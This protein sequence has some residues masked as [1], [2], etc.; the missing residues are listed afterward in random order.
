MGKK[1]YIIPIFV[2]H[3]GCPFDCVFCNQRKITGK[4]TALTGQEIE[5][6]IKEYVESIGEKKDKHIEIAFFGG[7][8]TGIDSEKQKEFLSIANKWYKS[9]YVDD[10]RLSTRPD[11]ID[12]DILLNLKE[13]NVS[14]IELGVQSLDDEVLRESCRGHI[15]HDV[16]SASY[17]IKKMGFKLGLQMMIGLPGDNFEKAMNT[18]KKMISYKPDF[19]RIYP[20]LVIKGTKLEELFFKNEYKPL[21]IDNAV[22]ICRELY[23]LFYR[24]DIPI[25]RIGLQPTENIMEGKDVVAGPFHPAFRQLVESEV[26]REAIDKVIASYKHEV[27]KV[28]FTLNPKFIS[29]LVGINKSNTIYFKSK[30]NIKNI[31]IIKDSELK[32]NEVKI[33]INDKIIIKQMIL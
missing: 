11:Y 7:S 29:N 12:K 31:K 32:K 21:S 23:K 15:A 19:V 3:H 33:K 20:T 28:E 24:N 4:D 18:A 6:Q 27:E 16:L 26:F 9:G 25:I 5:E 1:N 30:Y 17:L 14:T 2:P 13:Y 10:I 22:L 8:F